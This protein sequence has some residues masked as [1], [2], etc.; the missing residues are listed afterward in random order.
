[1]SAVENLYRDRVREF[2]D[3]FRESF[4]PKLGIVV[5]TAGVDALS[6]SLRTTALRRVMAHEPLAAFTD[7]TREHDFACFEI[8][9]HR[10]SFKIDC[11][12]PKLQHR[13]PDPKDPAKST[14]VLTLMLAAEY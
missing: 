10:F 4:D 5:T 13:S 9:G 6:S 2:N 14:R 12:D 3:A 8:A 7:L 1:M 11:Y